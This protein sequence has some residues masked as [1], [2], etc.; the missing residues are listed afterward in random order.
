MA[1]SDALLPEF[2]QEMAG[3]RKTLERVPA[4]KFG[5]QPHEKSSSMMSLA[6]HLAHLVG[7]TS[8][9]IDTG[10]LDLAPGGEPMA[11]PPTPNSVAELLATF[12]TNAAAARAAITGAS[13]ETL[14]QPWT[15]LHNG[16]TTLSLP[17]VAVLRTF[18]MNHVIH[19]RAQLGVYLRMNDVPVPSIYGPSAD[20]D[21]FA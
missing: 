4:D 5:W 18:V 2:D 3:V 19:H 9:M 20:E 1:I 17:R 8:M 13:D 12:D 21:P 15:L 11:P 6:G 10:Q 16:L 7:W 14:M